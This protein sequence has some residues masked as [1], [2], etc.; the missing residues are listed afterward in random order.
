MKKYTPTRE[1]Q[2]ASLLNNGYTVFMEDEES[3]TRT[4]IIDGNNG[5]V[6][7]IGMRGK[8]GKYLFN[9]SFKGRERAEEYMRQWHKEQAE[10]AQ[11]K[12]ERRKQ[13]PVTLQVGDILR[14]S[15]G[16]E[17]TN[18][19]YYQVISIKGTRTVVLREVSYAYDETG[20][21]CGECTPEPNSFISE[22]FER[23]VAE[24]GD[25]VRINECQYAHL[26]KPIAEIA[27]VRMYAPRYD[28]SYA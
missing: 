1:A 13:H 18:N 7:G 14:S 25:A 22:S 9:Y 19:N 28:S 10:I 20:S 21:M 2:E 5:K 3:N 16:Y 15:W 4:F 8:S 23:R 11:Y 27:G 17:Q 24:S 26:E 12:K 6:F